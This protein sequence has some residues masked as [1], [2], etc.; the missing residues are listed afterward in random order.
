[1]KI[2]GDLLIDG[3]VCTMK[4]SN[5][6]GR[7]I[8]SVF[9]VVAAPFATPLR[10]DIAAQKDLPTEKQFEQAEAAFEQRLCFDL[11]KK[12]NAN[13]P[14]FDEGMK[15]LAAA[16]DSLYGKASMPPVEEE[17]MGQGLMKKGCQDPL[18]ELKLAEILTQRNKPNPAGKYW[19]HAAEAMGKAGYP[20]PFQAMALSSAGVF[21][22][23]HGGR[24]AEDQYRGPLIGAV[25]A[26]MCGKWYTKADRPVLLHHLTR[27]CSGPTVAQRKKVW[28]SVKDNADADPVA[29][30][31]LEGVYH[32][33]AAWDVRGGGYANTVTDK[34]LKGFGEH[35][36]EARRALTKAWELDPAVPDPAVKMIAV[37]MGSAGRDELRLWFDRA[38]KARFDG[39]AAYHAYEYALYPRWQGNRQ[40]LLDF[41]IECYETRRFD[42]LVPL[43]LCNILRTV[44]T[45]CDAGEMRALLE[46][47]MYERVKESYD[48]TLAPDGAYPGDKVFRSRQ[49]AWCVAAEKWADARKAIVQIGGPVDEIGTGL[50]GLT[51]MEVSGSVNAY[52]G[53]ASADALKGRALLAQGKRTEGLAAYD[54]AIAA[55]KDPTAIRFMHHVTQVARWERDLEGGKEIS[56]K[57]DKD[58][59]GFTTVYGRW[60]I[61]KNGDL[62][63]A[64]DHDSHLSCY[65]QVE[66]GEAW[67]VRAEIDFVNR[68]AP[69]DA[70]GF[71]L[72]T[73]PGKT[74]TGLVI[75]P[76]KGTLA[77]GVVAEPQTEFSKVPSQ[78]KGNILI[79]RRSGGHLTLTVNGKEAFSTEAPPSNPAQPLRIGL[80]GWPLHLDDQ[81]RIRSI[82]AKS[83]K[84]EP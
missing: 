76:D 41:G 9:L 33:E 63:G 83:V 59:S 18:L 31:Y 39:P 13:Q 51:P 48:H 69:W 19:Y 44:R 24:G 82:T 4:L 56:L 2:V 10:A 78:E 22:F 20:P 28:M 72:S 17:Q 54:A 52:T 32:V 57:P 35:L 53:P 16:T 81:I 49:A 73:P 62:I 50:L 27:I 42:T 67:E 29:V 1:V 37:S 77:V 45:E 6:R 11:F 65:C 80:G 84:A 55:Q 21:A 61:D 7:V 47:G 5:F 38:V 40:A 36:Q 23:Y 68:S 74:Y 30:L 58:M 43:Y 79:L 64:A 60:H 15:F 75:N 26:M 25:K 46:P 12:I 3:D 8:A 71:T 34:G 66:F 70:T 14:W